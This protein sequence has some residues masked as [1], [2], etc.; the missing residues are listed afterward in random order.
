[1]PRNLNAALGIKAE[2]YHIAKCP[3]MTQSGLPATK[4]FHKVI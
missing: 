4:Q 2:Y 3:V 1:M